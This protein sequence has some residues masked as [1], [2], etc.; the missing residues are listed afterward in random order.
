MLVIKRLSE[1]SLE[2]AV[3]AWNS[4]YE[5][6]PFDMSMDV[7][8]F[9]ARLGLESLSPEMSFIA[10]VDH[11]PVGIVMS[12]ARDI[13]SEKVAWCGGMAVAADKRGRGVGKALMEALL[14]RF[15]EAGVTLATL[16]ALAENET[17]I[18]LYQTMG[19][20][21]VDQLLILEADDNLNREAFKS[22]DNQRF[23]IQFAVA[24]DAR[25]LLSSRIA[26]WQTQWQSLR[27]DGELMKV[28]LDGAVVGY[29]L[30]RRYFDRD[31]ALARVAI[32]QWRIEEDDAFDDIFQ[33]MCTGL[34]PDPE[35][36]YLKIAFNLPASDWQVVERLEW[37]GFK[38]RTEQVFMVKRL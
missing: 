9:A 35:D 24:Q 33:I 5:G 8:R 30:F 10:F 29:A 1:V 4:G 7:D 26:P 36:N 21:I 37:L 38:K 25:H 16:E 15:H 23:L 17:A 19:F 20:E 34:F 2:Q 32:Y 31:D 14:N 22:N 12:G 18:H 13:G 28:V 11:E 27:R 3:I 6:Y